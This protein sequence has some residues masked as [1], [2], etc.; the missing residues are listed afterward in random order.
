ME[1]NIIKNIKNI[2]NKPSV[3]QRLLN[4]SLPKAL[5]HTGNVEGYWSESSNCDQR[6]QRT[7]KGGLRQGDGK[8]D[9]S[10]GA[11]PNGLRPMPMPDTLL[12]ESRD[13]LFGI[14]AS[15]FWQFDN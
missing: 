7:D 9:N 2:N 6:P 15:D 1:H 11:H 12:V 14:A 3:Q 10:P 4:T 8:K 5:H 13:E